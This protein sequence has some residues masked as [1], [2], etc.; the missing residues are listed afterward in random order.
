M[1][2][3]G[4]PHARDWCD[5]IQPLVRVWDLGCLQCLCQAP[6]ALQLLK[7][8]QLYSEADLPVLPA[9]SSSLPSHC[10]T[11]PKWSAVPPVPVCREW[12]ADKQGSGFVPLP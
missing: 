10:G 4:V 8:N 9:L 1:A 12:C 5:R 3:A 11:F 2:V 7:G 6:E